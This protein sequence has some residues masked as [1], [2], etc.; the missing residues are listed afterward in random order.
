M[1]GDVAP[2]LRDRVPPRSQWRLDQQG[3]VI[4][5]DAGETGLSFLAI[6]F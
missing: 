2:L 4:L 1:P 6:R 5:A 3:R